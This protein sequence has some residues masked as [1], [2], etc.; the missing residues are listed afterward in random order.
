MGAAE[1]ADAAAFFFCIQ[2]GV[3]FA[4]ASSFF[5]SSVFFIAPGPH[6][7]AGFVSVFITS[8]IGA[9]G[10]G[11]SGVGGVGATLSRVVVI[12]VAGAG[13]AGGGGGGGEG[14]GV[15]SSTFGSIDISTI[16]AFVTGG[17]L[18]GTSGAFS[19]GKGGAGRDGGP[20]EDKAPI[21]RFSGRG[22]DTLEEASNVSIGAEVG[23]REA[24]GA[25]DGA[26]DETE[27]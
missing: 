21:R 1:A 2:A 12:Y 15:D 7:D 19:S 13:G 14:I 25:V 24:G 26:G 10:A 20:D 27:T 4:G 16:E 9:G 3:T 17:P 8:A 22:G 23:A 11:T 6:L 5:D 18:S